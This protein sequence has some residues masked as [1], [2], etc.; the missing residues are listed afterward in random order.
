MAELTVRSV[1]DRLR[2]ST[3]TVYALC[4]RKELEHH[5]ISHAIRISEA[6]L[7]KYL[8]TASTTPT[9]TDNMGPLSLYQFE[10]HS[11]Y[12]HARLGK[13]DR[14][15]P[16]LGASGLLAQIGCNVRETDTRKARATMRH[17]HGIVK[18]LW[19][20]CP[21]ELVRDGTVLL[22][23]AGYASIVKT[24][25]VAHGVHAPAARGRRPRA[26]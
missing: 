13:P 2:V 6:A 16:V 17:W 5:R 14:A 18:R 26:P 4:R 9:A 23:R 1:A 12:L 3:A 21:N 15:V 25:R 24:A 7:E 20:D 8:A 22:V 19:P 11:S 10:A